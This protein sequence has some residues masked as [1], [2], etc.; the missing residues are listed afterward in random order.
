MNYKPIPLP[1]LN[2]ILGDELVQATDAYDRDPTP[3]NRSIYHAALVR[4]CANMAAH[5]VLGVLHRVEQLEAARHGG[6]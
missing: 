4:R 5:A 1:E 2:Q 6:D 3:G